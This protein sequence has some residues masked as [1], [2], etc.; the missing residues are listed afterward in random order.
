MS[1]KTHEKKT[2]ENFIFKLSR[3]VRGGGFMLCFLVLQQTQTGHLLEQTAG[4]L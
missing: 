1:M 4:V 2:F 3:R